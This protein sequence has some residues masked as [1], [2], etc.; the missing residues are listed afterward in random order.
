MLHPDIGLFL[1][2]LGVAIMILCIRPMGLRIG[3]IGGVPTAGEA[4]SAAQGQARSG[5]HNLPVPHVYLA[6]SL[7]LVVTIILGV[8][9]SLRTLQSGGGRLGIAQGHVVHR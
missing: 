1:L 6:V 3:N 5:R 2:S 7:V 4:E 9:D 8:G